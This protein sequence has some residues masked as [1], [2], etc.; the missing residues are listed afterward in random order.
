M[1]VE[2]LV[3]Q[4]AVEALH[5]PVL[6]RLARRDVVPFDPA[7]LLPA[8][9]GVARQFGAIV[10]DDHGR[11]A[12][13]G[14]DPIQLAAD[15]YARERGVH[16]DRQRFA[17]EVVDHAQRAEATAIRKR[18]GHE[19]QAPALVGAARQHHRT[20]RARGPF[21]APSPPHS[22]AFFAVDTVELLVV[23][24]QPLPSQ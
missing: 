13:P 2:A 9:D 21:A 24:I 17:G 20:P 19:V 23:R 3:P 15:P 8:Q 16:H 5:D 4:T 14:D 1:L 18:I 22:Q 12:T 11:S 6:L 10:R 7:F